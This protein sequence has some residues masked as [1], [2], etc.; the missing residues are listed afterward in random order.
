MRE[1]RIG[2]II[3]IEIEQIQIICNK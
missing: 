1:I 3:G 2:P